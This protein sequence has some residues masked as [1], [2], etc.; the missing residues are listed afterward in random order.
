M[1]TTPRENPNT[2]TAQMNR[3]HSAS[4]PLTEDHGDLHDSKTGEYIRAAT[5]DER[6]ASDEGGETGAF[7]AEDGK[8]YYVQP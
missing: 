7:R 5:A 4:K 6:K 3:S 2:F 1:T 8:I